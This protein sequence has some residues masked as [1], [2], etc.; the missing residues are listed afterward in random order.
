MIADLRFENRIAKRREIEHE[1]SAKR[2]KI[3]GKRRFQCKIIAVDGG[4]SWHRHPAC[5]L[6][7]LA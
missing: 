4:G 7:W 1:S 2:K 5:A 3:A 6:V